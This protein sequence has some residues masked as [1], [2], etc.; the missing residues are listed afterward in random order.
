MTRDIALAVL[1][2]TLGDSSYL[3]GCDLLQN[4]IFER[5]AFR[6]VFL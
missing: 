3:D 5:H 6:I 2:L 1:D 4:L